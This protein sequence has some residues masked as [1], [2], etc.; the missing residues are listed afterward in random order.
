MESP[1]PLSP[2]ERF[3]TLQEPDRELFAVLA[4]VIPANGGQM[5]LRIIMGG[6]EL[7]REEADATAERLVDAG[8]LLRGEKTATEQY[9][10]MPEEAR[11][12]GKTLIEE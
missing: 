2:E 6:W 9:Y 1:T 10:S 4:D 8:L 3:E 11:L 7:K 12:F 5:S